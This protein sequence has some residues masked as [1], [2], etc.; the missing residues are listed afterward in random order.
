M[1][2]IEQR[3]AEL[4]DRVQSL[5]NKLETG[6]DVEIDSL[7]DF[8]NEVDPE[9]HD[10]TFLAIGYYFENK[11]GEGEFTAKEV[12][13]GYK[14]AELVEKMDYGESTVKGRVYGDLSD[15]IKSD[16]G[17]LHIPNYKVPKALEE[18]RKD[19]GETSE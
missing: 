17:I 4:E 14:L 5:E 19:Q 16:S 2:D 6:T 11:E 1:S 12:E 13:E 7:K 3:V 10:E 8:V 9:N 15:I 18:I